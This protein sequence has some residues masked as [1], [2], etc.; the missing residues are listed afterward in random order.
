MYLCLR[1]IVKHFCV[2]DVC[3][4]DTAAVQAALNRYDQLA[5]Q[6]V[7]EHG[8][9]K[10]LRSSNL[11]L[12]MC[13]ALKQEQELGRVC[14]MNELFMERGIQGLK[15]LTKHRVSFAPERTAVKAYMMDTALG[16][17]QLETTAGGGAADTGSAGTISTP[18][19]S[20]QEMKELRPQREQQQHAGPRQQA[21][22]DTLA[23][24]TGSYCLGHR[25]STR[26]LKGHLSI[27]NAK[28]LLQQCLTDGGLVNY[29]A[30][31]MDGDVGEVQV[32]PHFVGDVEW[33]FATLSLFFRANRSNT[34]ILH[35]RGYSRARTRLNEW[36]K[37]EFIEST[38][39]VQ[40]VAQISHFVAV[41][42]RVVAESGAALA[43]PRDIVVR[44]DACRLWETELVSSDSFGGDLIKATQ[45]YEN[46]AARLANY[47]PGLWPADEQ[48]TD[49]PLYPVLLGAIDCKVCLGNV[50]GKKYFGMPFVVSRR[51]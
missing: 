39:T 33:D 36:V 7:K 30:L 12:M 14:L 31:P 5:D 27:Q 17:M 24:M 38:G 19:Y 2:V 25:L 18:L 35:S 15:E 3:I 13:R 47:Q 44:I 43:V 21:T 37:L 16:K 42:G 1:T 29:P 9:P 41:A 8:A 46:P 48:A 11:H 51:Q 45:R 28:N 26:Q 4:G 23:P 40:Y 34:E 49:P 22:T 32:S 6:L 50:D 10:K 20:I